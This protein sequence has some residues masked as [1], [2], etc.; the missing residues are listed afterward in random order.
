MLQSSQRFDCDGE[1]MHYDSFSSPESG[2][3]RA[4]FSP[5]FAAGQPIFYKKGQLIYL[6]DQEPE[7]LYCLLEGTVRTYIASEAGEEML[8]TTY[9]AGSIFG[10]ASFFDG[11]PRVSSAAA[12]TDCQI[13]PLSHDT[14]SELFLKNPALALTMI[15][16]LARTVRLLSRH[17]DTMSF[18]TADKRLAAL[19]LNHPDSYTRIQVT[20]EELATALSVS[21]VTVSRLLSG[22]VKQGLLKTGYGSI[23]ILNRDRL[24]EI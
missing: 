15:T 22:F 4:L 13:I 8:L 3:P 14:V 16:Y 20:H 17:V 7:Y 5:F 19:L 24:S 10:E 6:Q 21:R 9:Q 18:Q 1:I 11:M 12:Q 23:V 2:L